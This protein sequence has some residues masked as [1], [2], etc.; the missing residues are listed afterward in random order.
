MNNHYLDHV[1]GI[2][3]MVGDSPL[4]L[5]NIVEWLIA[6]NAK[7]PK[8]NTNRVK[9]AALKDVIRWNFQDVSQYEKRHLWIDATYCVPA[10]RGIASK[11]T[12]LDDNTFEYFITRLKSKY[13]PLFVG[14]RKHDLRIT[15]AINRYE[16]HTKSGRLPNRKYLT[17]FLA[18]TGKRILGHSIS[19]ESLRRPA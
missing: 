17:A 18:A 7:W 13:K 2:L 10:S 14:I 19:A 9:R 16:I 11:I 4:T 12:R 1:Q 6:I 3:D 15:E 8:P 5:R